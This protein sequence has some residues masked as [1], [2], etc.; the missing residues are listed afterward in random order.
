MEAC[1]CAKFTICALKRWLASGEADGDSGNE[2][3]D[4]Q[5]KVVRNELV[6]AFKRCHF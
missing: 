4:H 2:Q 3:Q 5:S 1:R 6:E